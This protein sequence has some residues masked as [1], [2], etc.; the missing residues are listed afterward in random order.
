MRN[1]YITDGSPEGFFTA[2][3][4]AYKD[5]NAFLTSSN[6]LQTSLDDVFISVSP[7]DEKSARVVKKLRATDK[8]CLYEIDCVL[9]TAETDKEQA[10]FA[11][12]RLL[13]KHRS[14]V[15]EMLIL[16]EVRQMREL[17][18]RVGAERHLLS[19]FLRFQE[20]ASGAFYAPCTPDNDVVE[21]LMP[22]FA[23]RFKNSAFVI[24]DVARGLAGIYNGKEWLVTAVP[25]AEI[26]LSENEEAFSG[27][28]KKYYHTV[29]IPARKNT[30]LMK[31]YMPVRYW[32]FM[33]EKQN[34]EIE[35]PEK[36]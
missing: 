25:E 24:H 12:I 21:L 6:A 27:L 30:R 32:K 1:V 8:N 2:V 23:A 5:K 10:A 29:Y 35:F 15:R 31:G 28:W 11:Y 19:G 17:C 3:F 22:H 16:A 7:S 4:D 34:E 14:P 13:L 36:I 9:R 26:V 20:T 18:D 33:P